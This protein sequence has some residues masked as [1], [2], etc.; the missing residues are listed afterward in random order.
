VQTEGL[1]FG[2]FGIGMDKA[3]VTRMAISDRSHH[4]EAA[5]APVHPIIGFTDQMNNEISR[6]RKMD[7]DHP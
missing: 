6:I 4:H 1:A 2:N 5:D 3:Q 7:N